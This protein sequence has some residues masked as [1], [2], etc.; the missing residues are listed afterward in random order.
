M[1]ERLHQATNFLV[2]FK[3]GS[4]VNPY[5]ELDLRQALLRSEQ[6]CNTKRTLDKATWKT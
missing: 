6:Y 3:K 1:E 2:F 4:L 5:L